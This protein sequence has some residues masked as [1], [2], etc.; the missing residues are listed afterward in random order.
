MSVSQKQ[1][2]TLLCTMDTDRS[3]IQQNRC[4][5]CHN[6]DYIYRQKN[7]GITQNGDTVWQAILCHFIL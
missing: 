7:Y 2:G 1:F 4:L 3:P 6:K 5:L